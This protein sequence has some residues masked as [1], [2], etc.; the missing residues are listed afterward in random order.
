MRT[1]VV[2]E[3][4]ILRELLSFHFE[5]RHLLE[6]VETES[7][8]NARTLID[9][10]D[11]AFD[12][13]YCEMESGGEELVRHLITQ[14]KSTYFLCSSLG[15]QGSK[16]AEEYPELVH[17]VAPARLLGDC[18][19]G[20]E[21]FFGDSIQELRPPELQ[22]ARIRVSL[23]PLLNPLPLDLYIRLGSQK[24]LRMIPEGEY[25]GKEDLTYF[26][27]KKKLNHLFLRSAEVERITT[28]LNSIVFGKAKVVTPP[29]DLKQRSYAATP[30]PPSPQSD[31]PAPAS[32]PAAAEPPPRTEAERKARSEKITTEVTIDLVRSLGKAMEIAEK[33]GFTPE[34]QEMTKTNVLQTIALVRR[35]PKLSEILRA[36]RFEQGKYLATHSMLLAH[37]AC[38]LATQM[39]WTNDMTYQKLSLAAFLHDLPLKNHEL[40]AIQTIEELQ[41]KVGS[42][43]EEEIR[44]FREH[45]LVA[46][47][48]ARKLSE[49]P[50]D[51]D[52][53]ISQHHELPSGKGF[54]RG[55]PLTRI[56]PLA[57]LFIVAHDL[58]SFL[59]EKEGRHDQLTSEA[60]EDFI[61]LRS[62][63]YSS[64]NFRKVLAG[65]RKI[66][67]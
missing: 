67:A 47:E 29:A 54:P 4:R 48:M 27:T 35:A 53:I 40:A 2:S 19:A 28:Q 17:A 3:K 50:P 62:N 64:G 38:A 11:G 65:A 43:S 36:L 14:G 56:A 49:V 30:A 63:T 46:A 18:S 58:V 66:K 51:V 42:F 31:P 1:L 13:I 37:V 60:V 59:M 9:G 55:L 12:L 34:V 7:A 25:F 21:R 15:P 6:V 39:D 52:V 41:Q 44:S 26:Q 23:L 5:G 22:F 57:A 8:A 33:L 61:L 16:L 45:P 24:Y 10:E 32:A 20:I